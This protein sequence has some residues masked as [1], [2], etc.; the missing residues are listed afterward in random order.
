MD[1]LKVSDIYIAGYADNEN[2]TTKCL[3]YY[4]DPAENMANLEIDA[5]YSI[6]VILVCISIENEIPFKQWHYFITNT[7]S[8][9]RGN[10]VSNTEKD[11]CP[12]TGNVR[13]LARWP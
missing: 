12:P 2:L 7:Y 5:Q 1:N 3:L 9:I 10:T 4:T 11:R 6:L 13:Q 8:K